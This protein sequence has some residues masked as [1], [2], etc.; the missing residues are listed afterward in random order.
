MSLESIFRV[1][2]NAQKSAAE[3]NGGTS[4]EKAAIDVLGGLTALLEARI[5]LHR[6]ASPAATSAQAPAAAK[7]KLPAAA[8]SPEESAA[9][10]TGF[11]KQRP[12]SES[13]DS[14][15]LK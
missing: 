1:V 8:P 14:Y 5:Q 6:R 7:P 3:Q 4:E 11:Q 2:S 10:A 13:G 12:A 9:S 15:D